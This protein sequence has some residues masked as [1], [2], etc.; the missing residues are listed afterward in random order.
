MYKVRMTNQINFFY[1]NGLEYKKTFIPDKAYLG[2]SGGEYG[3]SLY[4]K[5]DFYVEDIINQIRKD[6]VVKKYIENNELMNIWLDFEIFYIK[7]PN[8][9]AKTFLMDS[10]KEITFVFY[11]NEGMTPEFSFKL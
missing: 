6:I 10:E 2:Q 7:I 9:P 8:L 4:M 11:K 3:I 5:S 1:K